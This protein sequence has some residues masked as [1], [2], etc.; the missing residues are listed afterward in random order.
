MAT[1]LNLA[2]V[3]LPSSF[4]KH[5]ILNLKLLNLYSLFSL[6]HFLFSPSWSMIFWSSRLQCCRIAWIGP[7]WTATKLNAAT[8]PLWTLNMYINKK[9]YLKRLNTSPQLQ[10]EES[11]GFLINLFVEHQE[12]F[13]QTDGLTDSP[14]QFNQN[15]TFTSHFYFTAESWSPAWLSWLLVHNLYTKLPMT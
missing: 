7:V 9:F 6:F 4:Y 5:V 14:C 11:Q 12:D 13:S 10:L 15:R 2:P 3:F 1:F 8:V